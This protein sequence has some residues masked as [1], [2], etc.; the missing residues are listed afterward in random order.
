MINKIFYDSKRQLRNVETFNL[1]QDQ[2]GKIKK[3]NFTPQKYQILSDQD[4]WEDKNRNSSY[5]LGKIYRNETK[6]SKRQW[7]LKTLSL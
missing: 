7:N 1:V 6:K 2:Q 4:E 3:Y 5:I